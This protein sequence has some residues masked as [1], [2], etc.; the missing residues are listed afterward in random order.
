MDNTKEDQNQFENCILQLYIIQDRDDR[1]KWMVQCPAI[2]SLLAA[3]V[4][5]CA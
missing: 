4:Q 5:E 3:S 2:S 1:K